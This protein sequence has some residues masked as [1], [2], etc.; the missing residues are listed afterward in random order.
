ML[1]NRICA[2]Y[3]PIQTYLE[4]RLYPKTHHPF[5]IVGVLVSQSRQNFARTLATGTR[6]LLRWRRCFR[7]SLVTFYI[8]LKFVV[9][10]VALSFLSGL[11]VE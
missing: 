11:R 7:F 10:F 3:L 6:K 1:I 9:R 2:F 8:S 5:A 4:S